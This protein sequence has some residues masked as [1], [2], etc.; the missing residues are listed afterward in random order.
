MNDVTESNCHPTQDNE[1][2]VILL[3]IFT[4]QQKKT[5]VS[6]RLNLNVTCNNKSQIPSISH[7]LWHRVGCFLVLAKFIQQTYKF[8]VRLVIICSMKHGA[9]SL[10]KLLGKLCV[11][12][13]SL[14]VKQQTASMK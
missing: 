5:Q 14:Q 2:S 1:N 9:D 4:Q 6:V 8:K 11:C 10:E 13:T 7:H 12:V 3:L